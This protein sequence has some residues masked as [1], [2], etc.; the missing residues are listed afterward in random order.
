MNFNHVIKII[1]KKNPKYKQILR[2]INISVE[3]GIKHRRDYLYEYGIIM[4]SYLFEKLS[5]S[6]VF[7][8][9]KSEI[10]KKH[11][12]ITFGDLSNLFSLL[13]VV[14]PCLFLVFVIELIYYKYEMN[15]TWF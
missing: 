12:Q 5:S 15:L 10:N 1:N 2:M 11:H 14:F 8:Q 7:Y 3:H 6:K 9:I 4:L 13:L